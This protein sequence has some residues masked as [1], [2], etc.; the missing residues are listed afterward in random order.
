MWDLVGNP[1][2][3]FSH[4]E[5]HVKIE[6]AAIVRPINNN[7]FENRV[8]KLPVETDKTFR[9]KENYLV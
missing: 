4:N 8:H 5:A 6:P 1:D 2:D 9:N 3:R 7:E